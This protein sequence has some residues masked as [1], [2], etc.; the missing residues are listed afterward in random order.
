MI[1]F[2][3]RPKQL[4]PTHEHFFYKSSPTHIQSKQCENYENSKGH[5]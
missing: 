3:Q 2:Y 5:F 1:I 4:N